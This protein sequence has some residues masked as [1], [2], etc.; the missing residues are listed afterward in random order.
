MHRQQGTPVLEILADET[1]LAIFS[2]VRERPH[3]AK[4][5][6]EVCDASLKT[7]YRRVEALEEA[8]LVSAV[9]RIDEGGNHH[10]IYTTA[11]D[12]VEIVIE[13]DEPAIDVTVQESDDVEQFV[14]VW[15]ELQR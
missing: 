10:T 3:S 4:K 6:E 14:G 5:L 8:G 1:A 2:R 15:R 12:A 9:T 7:V 13:P 11:I